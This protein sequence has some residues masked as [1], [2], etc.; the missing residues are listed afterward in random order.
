MPESQLH[1]CRKVGLPTAGDGKNLNIQIAE[2]TCFDARPADF[3]VK[4]SPDVAFPRQRLERDWLYQDAG[5]DIARV[6]TSDNDSEKERAM[7][8]KR[9]GAGPR[10]RSR[11]EALRQRLDQ[12]GRGGSSRLR[13]ALAVALFRGL[14]ARRKARLQALRERAAQFIYVKHGIFGCM[15]G[16]AGKYDIPDEQVRDYTFGFK[17]GGQLCLG[18]VLEDGTI[19]HEVLLEK[20]AGAICYP[21]LSWDARTLVFSMRDNFE[22]DSYYLYTMDMATRRVTADHLPHPQERQA[23]ARR[24]L[25]AGIPAGRPD[26]VHVDARRAYQRL[27]VPRRREHL[28]LRCRRRQYPPSDVRPAH[29]QQP[30]GPGR[31]P[32]RLH[33]LGV[34]RPQR[35]VHPSADLP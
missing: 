33:P 8:Q 11:A 31:R 28:L 35:A 32:D 30:P 22:T 34:Q 6:F 7:V 16:L 1:W 13:S 27:L 19:K 15:Q 4:N 18:T 23:P 25:R 29:D 26:R 2:I 3:P 17:Q 14:C 10:W 24:R 12:L 20:P 21:N 9:V 5:L